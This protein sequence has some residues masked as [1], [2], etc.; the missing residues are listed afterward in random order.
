MEK[1]YCHEILFQHYF[2]TEH[3]TG[4]PFYFKMLLFKALFFTFPTITSGSASQQANLASFI[5][6]T[7]NSPA[8]CCF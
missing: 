7:L 6:L 3:T 4:I 2:D 8:S 5:W 1:K